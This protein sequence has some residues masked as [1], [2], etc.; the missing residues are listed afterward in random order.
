MAM[1]LEQQKALARARARMR[2]SEP[3][4]ADSAPAADLSLGDVAGMAVSN[5]PASAANF[6]SD[7]TYPIRHPIATAQGIAGM[8]E[9]AGRQA[10]SSV[11]PEGAIDPTTAEWEAVKNYYIGR[12]GSLEGFKQAL[13]EDPVGVA[14]DAS[15]VLTGGGTLVG[16]LPGMAG[17]VGNIVAKTG[18]ILDPVS[19]AG[20]V[21][22]GAGKGARAIAGTMSG[23]GDAP[24]QEAFAAS[25]AGGAKRQAF[26]D[27]MRG[28]APMTDVVDEAKAALANI[29]NQRSN[30]YQQGIQTTRA[31]TAPVSYG[32]V[33]AALQ[34]VVS[35]L[36][37]NGQWISGGTSR[38]IANRILND[39]RDWS[40]NPG[41]QNA[42]GL[43]YLKRRLDIYAKTPGPGMS[44][45]LKQANR[46]VA[47]VQDAIR[48]EIIRA[49]PNYAKTMADYS[50]SSDMINDIEKTLSLGKKASTD[51]TLRKLQ[52][53]MRNNVQTNYG[54]RTTMAKELENAGADTLMP[55][56]AGQSLNQIAP[57]GIARAAGPGLVAAAGGYLMNPA[58]L[59]A[60]IPAGLAMLASSPR[61]QGEVAGL[62][63]DAARGVDYVSDKVITPGGK[64]AIAAAT[65][66]PVRAVSQEVG[67]RARDAN[68]TITDAEG[69]VYDK[70][71]RRLKRKGMNITFGPD[72]TWKQN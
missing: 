12:Y 3:V 50:K 72:G 15:A 16:R 21:V 2:V 40:Q 44:G 13:A 66:R 18:T 35:T 24:L 20:R 54:Q 34:Q 70:K 22:S 41:M 14:A 37:P 7:L 8:A 32:N 47:S 49:D 27:N 25:R 31:T 9:G 69:N 58:L 29:S 46:I 48:K 39:I 55:A 23:V 38:A 63:G 33:R 52:S 1:T 65:S 6:V 42:A 30:A 10:L 45:D 57:R 51:T 56:L 36:A 62:L 11:L 61:L 68:E 64:K 59:P 43:D 28:D 5:I 67:G 19:T 26:R 53:V 60:A 4:V 17:R 71:G